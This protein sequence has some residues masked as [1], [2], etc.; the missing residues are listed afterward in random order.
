MKILIGLFL[1]LFLVTQ[2]F[3]AK[4]IAVEFEYTKPAESFNIY[5]DGS[6]ICSGSTVGTIICSDLTIDYG[7]HQFTMTAV[8]D[9]IETL[10]SNP[11][12][13]SFS[14]VQGSGPTIINFNITVED[15][16]VVPL[17]AVK[18]N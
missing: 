4:N 9:G 2:A 12:M 5:M 14:P 18:V 16:T 3:A 13:W 1:S 15:G 17:T 6:M 8:T 11:Y 7:M 10:H